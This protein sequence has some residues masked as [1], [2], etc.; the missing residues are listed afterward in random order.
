MAGGRIVK[1][2]DYIVVGAGSAGCVLADRLSR[3]GTNSVLVLEAGGSDNSFWIKTTIGY[4]RNFFDPAGQLD[5][6]DRTGC[7]IG[8][9]IGYWPRGKVWVAPARSMRSSI[10]AVF[11]A[12]STTGKRPARRGGP[13]MRRAPITSRSKAGFWRTGPSRVTVRSS[14]AM[15]GTTRMPATENYFAMAQELGLP[16]TEDC[17]GPSPEGVTRYRITTRRGRR[18]SAADAFLRP[19]LARANVTLVKDCLVERILIEG[20]HAVGVS[21]RTAKGIETF[22]AGCDIIVSAGA[23]NSPKLLQASGIGPQACSRGSAFPSS[24]KMTMSAAIF[25]TISASAIITR[26]ASRPSTPFSPLWGKVLQGMRYVLTRR[27]PLSLSVN[28]CGGFVRSR[29]GLARP[30]LQLY[31]NPLT[32]TTAPANK[33]PKIGRIPSPASSCPSSR[34]VR[35]AAADRDRFAGSGRAAA[36]HPEFAVD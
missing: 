2:F 25:R 16:V 12:I 1:T 4:G 10:A 9:R 24:W 22:R 33:G 31:L 28:Q 15:S 32:Y 18:W 26:R 7:G 36:D 3:S 17:N 8:G 20:R 5:V 6:P 23:V 35:P 19:A 11:P 14:S 30:D 27:G 21:V 29:A 34:H 13:G